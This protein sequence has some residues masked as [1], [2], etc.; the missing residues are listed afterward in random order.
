MMFF[1]RG[2][3]HVSLQALQQMKENFLVCGV[4]CACYFG[5]V[6]RQKLRTMQAK[7]GNVSYAVV[8]ENYSPYIHT[9]C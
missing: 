4:T 1:N 2:F 8:Q 9:N 5:Q 3:P 7:L 6:Y